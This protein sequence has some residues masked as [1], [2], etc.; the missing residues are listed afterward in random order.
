[1]V[2]KINIFLLFSYIVLQFLDLISTSFCYYRDTPIGVESNPIAENI[3]SMGIGAWIITK[4]FFTIF[5]A[6]I[7]S[8]SKE[9]K[10]VLCLNLFL[11]Y[12][13]YVAVYGNFELIFKYA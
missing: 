4:I 5:W 1:M 8:V 13:Y 9:D 7:V 6:F 12:I 3:L 2:A 11:V 10:R